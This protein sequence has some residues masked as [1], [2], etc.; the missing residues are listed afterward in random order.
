MKSI[1]KNIVE[2][3]VWTFNSFEYNYIQ[4]AQDAL[5]EAP[6]ELRIDSNVYYLIKLIILIKF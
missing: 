5:R 1:L 2:G 3:Y 6:R 4:K